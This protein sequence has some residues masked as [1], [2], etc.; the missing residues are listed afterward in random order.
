MKKTITLVILLLSITSIRVKGQAIVNDPLNA[1]INSA[2][3]G[4][5]AASNVINDFMAQL[6][7]L[8][9]ASDAVTQ[10]QSVSQIAH[11]IDDLVCLT[12]EFNFYMNLNTSYSCAKFLNFRIVEMNISYATELL[13][14]VILAK[15]LFT[16][17]SSERMNI[18]NRV[19]EVL[20]KTVKDMEAIIA[21]IKSFS[22]EN[23]YK[24]IMHKIYTAD[25]NRT[26]A[27]SR[28]RN[29]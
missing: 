4:L 28:Y 21:Q 7:I 8:E 2:I 5:N 29:R 3:E 11:L 20:E 18:L 17:K 6:Q 9:L 27:Y 15:N 24:K 25:V 22:A 10:L 1:G 13:T 19:K 12:T 14:S 16:M 26:F 23:I